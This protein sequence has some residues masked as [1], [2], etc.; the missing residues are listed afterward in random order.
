MPIGDEMRRQLTI[1]ERKD[2]REMFVDKK[3]INLG[4]RSSGLWGFRREG[5]EGEGGGWKW[6]EDGSV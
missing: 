4:K 2:D 5:A 1:E 3:V 6:E